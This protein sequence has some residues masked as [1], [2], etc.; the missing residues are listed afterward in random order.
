MVA[1]KKRIES[2]ATEDMKILQFCSGQNSVVLHTINQ[3]RLM[4]VMY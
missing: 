3:P 2:G 1:E 4:A